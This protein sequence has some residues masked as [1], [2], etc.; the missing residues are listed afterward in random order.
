MGDDK[1]KRFTKNAISA[2]GALDTHV[3]K[4]HLISRV[5]IEW[6]SCT[7]AHGAAL[8]TANAADSS[9]S[10]SALAGFA[11]LVETRI[12][13]L[14]GK[15]AVQSQSLRSEFLNN[16]CHID[17]FEYSYSTQ[18]ALLSWPSRRGWEPTL[19]PVEVPGLAQAPSSTLATDKM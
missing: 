12:A 13:S 3:S 16:S 11:F 8:C 1:V 4:P 15:I 7:Q 14:C 17:N 10:S 6:H 2:G 9:P 5:L 18:P 19:V